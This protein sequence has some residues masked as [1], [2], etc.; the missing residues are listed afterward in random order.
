[1]SGLLEVRGMEDFTHPL[2]SFQLPL[3]AILTPQGG[4]T[5]DAPLALAHLLAIK[6]QRSTLTKPQTT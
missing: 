2:W 3:S 1:M 5:E 6:T 4:G